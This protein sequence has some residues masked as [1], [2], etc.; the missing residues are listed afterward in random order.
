MT[1]AYGTGP[2][3]HRLVGKNPTTRAA[4]GVATVSENFSTDVGFPD[5]NLAVT[6]APTRGT[7]TTRLTD[8]VSGNVLGERTTA[9]L[10]KL[11]AVVPSPH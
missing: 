8:Y 2:E 7:C 5:S 9:G 3:I 4:G 11:Y 10:A 6:T 1:I